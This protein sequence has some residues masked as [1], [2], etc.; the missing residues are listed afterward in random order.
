MTDRSAIRQLI[1]WDTRVVAAR[2]IRTAAPRSD[3]FRGLYRE[4]HA[5]VWRSARRL[6]VP[7]EH[8][9]DVMQDVFLAAYRH[10]DEFEGRSA[11]KTWL[12]GI[13]KNVVR[14][15]VR[16]ECRH[17][18]RVHAAKTL[19]VAPDERDQTEEHAAIDLMDRLLARLDS[20]DQRDAFILVELEGV[21]AIEVARMTRV[22]VNTVY[23]RLRLARERL[24]RELRRLSARGS[25]TP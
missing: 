8:L 16:R 25:R 1:A 17:H 3:P 24:Q 4:H 7:A 19:C 5:F 22:S 15:H 6:G 20:V 13:V 11:L 10:R 14:M 2:D 23:S 21:S 9:D 18:R 12:Y